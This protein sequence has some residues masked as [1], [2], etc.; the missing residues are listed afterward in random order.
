MRAQ[1]GRKAAPCTLRGE[2][3][4]DTESL[5]SEN[6]RESVSNLP[7]PLLGASS[8]LQPDHYLSIRCQPREQRKLTRGAPLLCVFR[9]S[10]VRK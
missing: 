6:I 5:A 4:I 2:E 10:S 8:T 9:E 7:L 3:E 1:G